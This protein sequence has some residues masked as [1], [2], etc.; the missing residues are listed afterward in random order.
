MTPGTGDKKLD[1][2]YLS[3][4]V[5]VIYP[6]SSSRTATPTPDNTASI[7][8]FDGAAAPKA[9]ASAD[10]A[11]TPFYGQSFRTYPKDCPTLNVQ[12]FHAADVPKRKPRLTKG[13][14]KQEKEIK[15]PVRPKK[16]AAFSESDSRRT[17]A[18]YQKLLEAAE[19]KNNSTRDSQNRPS[20]RSKFENAGALDDSYRGH[21]RVAVN[22]DYLF[23]IN[24]EERELTP[25]YWLGPSYEVRRGT[26]FFQEGSGL[27]P[28]EE[29]LA[30][31]LEE[32][33][34]KTKPWL[35]PGRLRSK[36]EVKDTA[37]SVKAEEPQAADQE[38]PEATT[39]AQKPPA[40][41]AQSPQPQLP[42][43]RLFGAYM[44]NVATYQDEKTAWMT[45]D[46][47]L[48]WVAASVYERF[49]GGGYMSG[50][51]LIRGYSEPKKA[52][53][54]KAAKENPSTLGLH[55][56]QKLVNR[57]SAPPTTGDPLEDLGY[58]QIVQKE[59][60]ERDAELQRR[61][62]SFMESEGRIT[63]KTE[64]QIRQREEEEIEDDYNARDGEAQGREIEHLV[65]VTHGIGQRLG[66][67]MESLNFVHDVNV[68]RKNM[69]SVYS[70][71]ADLKALNSE[72][73]AGQGNCRVQVLPVCWRHFIEFPRQR[74]KKGEHDLGDVTDEDDNCEPSDFEPVVKRYIDHHQLDPSLEDI[75]VEGVTFARSLIS[76]LA[77]DILLYQSSY[78]EEISRAVVAETNRILKLFQERN[79]EFKGK[80]HLMGHSLGS[81]IFF[82][83]LCRQRETD[84]D[85]T[86]RP[87]RFW[88]S[89][90]RPDIR[91]KDE[92]LEFDFDA[93]NFFCLGSPVGL[94][95][96]LK[97]RTIA[98]RPSPHGLA[99]KSLPNAE[100]TDDPF[101]TTPAGTGL[102]SISPVSGLSTSVS[103][104]KAEQLF[105]IFHPSDPISYRMEP[106]ISPAMAS[107]K[108]QALPYTKK[109]IFGNVA[110][111]GLTG[112]G[113]K[114][115]QSVSG[116]WSSLSA[117]LASNILNRSLGITSEEVARLGTEEQRHGDKKGEATGSQEAAEQSAERKRQLAEAAVRGRRV[118]DNGNS[119]TLIDDELETLYSTF[120]KRHDTAH[121]NEAMS[122]LND[123]S[124]KARKLRAEEAKVRALNRNGRVD[125]NIQESALDFNPINTIASHMSYWGD[126]DVTHFVLSQLL[127]GKPVGRNTKG[128]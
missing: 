47:M 60:Q 104:P 77:L 106:L 28:C 119:V 100:Y 29:N 122:H 73:G 14:Q 109:G 50:V 80:V 38:P 123:E 75:T 42:T 69:K 19:D 39:S 128:N 37:G 120:Q 118:S 21:T 61:L 82:D 113:A 46:G 86:R 36:S 41:T 76:D 11:I 3:S 101:L 97:G 33:Y 25:V 125:Y 40:G 20:K 95:Q 34:L 8:A 68:L 79:P 57:R 12:W 98:A 55:E 5:D 4:A 94:F 83:V 15:P 16:F 63:G 67:R 32:G 10:H 90:N 48:S 23:D 30:A 9:T 18:R 112:I 96:M 93:S 102:D 124:R 66:L 103:C 56:R 71:S 85:D 64:E 126:E 31:Q 87:L 117:G 43:Y 88:P 13:P 24:I 49:A 108:P 26:W 81:A 115:G 121:G 72:L 45:T 58:S 105:N 6:W 59:T 53:D 44:N 89:H 74:Q 110:P 111:Q 116:I 99:S 1:K 114:V 78:R 52:Q 127:S 91:P 84:P 54:T 62:S 107:L 92:E 2:S 17:E 7:A 51:K 27:R 35:L 65:L 22:E 70:N